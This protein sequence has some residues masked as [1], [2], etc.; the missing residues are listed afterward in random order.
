MLAKK[1]SR[2]FYHLDSSDSE[3]II[4]A[5]YKLYKLKCPY[6][7]AFSP[8]MLMEHPLHGDSQDGDVLKV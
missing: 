2:E 7:L 3:G 1:I 8:M 4:P 5:K 6:L